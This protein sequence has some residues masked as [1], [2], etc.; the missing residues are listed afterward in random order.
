MSKQFWGFLLAGVAVVGIAL[1]GL[2]FGTKSSHLA[3]DGKFLKVRTLALGKDACLVVVDFRVANTSAVPF[4]VRDV[5]LKLTPASGAEV[6]GSP[7]SK[8]DIDHVFEAEKLIGPRFNDVLSIEDRIAPNKTLDRMTAAR[9]E[10][11][12]SLVDGRKS[13][14][15]RLEDVDGTAAE[16]REGP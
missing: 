3:L 15:L 7:A 14:A 10:L 11:P 9:F 12:E 16:V 5:T 1:A 2:W 6:D 13:L 8:T 4:V